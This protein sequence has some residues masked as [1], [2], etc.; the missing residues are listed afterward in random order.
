ML[1]LR[2]HIG[3]VHI[4][5]ESMS[6]ALREETA[7]VWTVALYYGIADQG[8]DVFRGSWADCRDV[9]QAIWDA[10]KGGKKSYDIL[11]RSTD[12]E[13]LRLKKGATILRLVPE[14]GS[15]PDPPKAPPRRKARKP[16]SKIKT[17]PKPR[18][19]PAKRGA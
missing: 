5:G 1:R 8:V 16:R 14:P 7:A 13:A 6:V 10:V 2:D 15:E 9:R 11:P 19:G 18:K 12:I 17:A 4:V 3:D